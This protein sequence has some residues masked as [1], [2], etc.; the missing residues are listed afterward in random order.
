MISCIMTF[1]GNKIFFVW[2]EKHYSYYAR[3]MAKGRWSRSNRPKCYARKKILPY[4]FI[5]AW[6]ERNFL[7]KLEDFKE[8]KSLIPENLQCIS[9]LEWKQSRK[10]SEIWSQAVPAYLQPSDPG[11]GCR[12]PWNPDSAE[13]V[14]PT[15]WAPD[16]SSWPHHHLNHYTNMRFWNITS[17][18]HFI[19]ELVTH[20]KVSSFSIKDRLLLKC[21]VWSAIN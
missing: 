18:A 3:T 21:S 12:R 10:W 6:F 13:P 15:A 14:L 20:F 16:P 9:D 1:H 19:K 11:S 7:L 8:K 5:L 2:P 4:N 17:A